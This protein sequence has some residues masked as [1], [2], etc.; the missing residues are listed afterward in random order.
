MQDRKPHISQAPTVNRRGLRPRLTLLLGVILGVLFVTDLEPYAARWQVLGGDFIFWNLHFPRV[1][2]A[3]LGGVALA[4]SG[5]MMQTLF[6][7]PLA[8]PF[9]I[10]ITPGASFGVALITYLGA[11]LGLDNNGASFA[12]QPLAALGGA[13]LV[14]SIQLALHKKLSQIHSLLLV[15]LVLGYFFGAAVDIITQTAQAQQVKQFVMWG[16]GGFDRVLPSQLIILGSSAAV[17]LLIIAF[18]RHTFNTYLLGDIHVESA[19][20]STQAIRLWLII[21]SA[22]MAAIVTAYCGPVSFVGLIAPHISRKIQGT[23]SHGPN[24]LTTAFAGAALTL[25]AD[26]LANQLIPNTLLPINAVLSIIGA[27][28]V[29]LMLTR[30]N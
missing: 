2:A 24:I 16:M 25:S 23:E 20:K 12:L 9:L 28:V 27:P 30:K 10:G 21:G 15:G 11:E 8:G 19:G 17:G 4:W 26:A 7:N 1:L 18:H 14:L 13:L 22:S 5:L 3:L 29:I 6:R